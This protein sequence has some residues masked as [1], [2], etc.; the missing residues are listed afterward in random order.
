MTTDIIKRYRRLRIA[1]RLIF[2]LGIVVSIAA[3]ILY[4]EPNFISQA[5]SAWAP[6]ALFLCVE[7]I[8]RIPSRSSGRS[9]L[10]ITVTGIVAAIAAWIS[11][12]HMVDVA[13]RYGQTGNTPYLLPISVDGLIVVAS[14]CLVEIGHVL[15]RNDHTPKPSN[16]T[17][18]MTTSDNTTPKTTTSVIVPADAIASQIAASHKA[19]NNRPQ[20]QAALF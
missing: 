19:N 9:W 12:W 16:H 8:S 10:R 13:E 18:T 11:Y 15:D 7:L 20:G 14:I 4:A 17:N 5:I 3:N 6:L 2:A 1:V